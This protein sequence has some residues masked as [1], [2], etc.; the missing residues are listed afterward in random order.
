[1][2]AAPDAQ[3]LTRRLRPSRLRRRHEHPADPAGARRPP[4]STCAALAAR[5]CEGVARAEAHGPVGEPDGHRPGDDVRDL[6]V[7]VDGVELVPTVRPRIQ[8]GTAAAALP[9]RR[10]R[11][12][13]VLLDVDAA[14]VDAAAP[15]SASPSGSWLGEQRADWQRE[16]G[17]A[18]RG[19]RRSARSRRVRVGWRN[20]LLSPVDSATCAS[21]RPCAIRVLRSFAPIGVPPASAEG[22]MDARAASFNV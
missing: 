15:R 4:R 10:V 3:A 9:P 16:T 7:A 21:V 14:E 8:R 13:E 17:R 11:R 12:H 18:A 5:E 1:M 2:G 20:S 19:S 22:W 6:D